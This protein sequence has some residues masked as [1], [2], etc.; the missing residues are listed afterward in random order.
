M[1]P[2]A[3]RALRAIAATV[4]F[5]FGL[6]LMLIAFGTPREDGELS[7]PG[8]Q[9]PWYLLPPIGTVA[10]FCLRPDGTRRAWIPLL[11]ALTSFA[12]WLLVVFVLWR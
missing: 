10:A 11:I 9:I 7:L 3:H 12:G 1:P 2:G 8:Y 6:L 5:L 4:L